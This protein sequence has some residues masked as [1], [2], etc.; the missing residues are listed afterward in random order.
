VQKT[1]GST[2]T[3]YVYDANGSLAAEYGN[4]TY[5]VSGTVYLTGDHLGSTRVV[6]SANGT[7]LARYDYAPFGE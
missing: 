7:V 5:P 1:V 3:V 2:N 4:A 6:T